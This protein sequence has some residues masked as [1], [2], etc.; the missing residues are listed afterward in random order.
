MTIQVS[1]SDLDS[2]DLVGTLTR[3]TTQVIP[4][5]SWKNPGNHLQTILNDSWYSLLLEFFDEFCYATSHFYRGKGIRSI[6]TPVTT[7]SISS[8]MGLG[9]DSLPV[10]AT[11]NGEPVYLADSMQFILEVGARINRKGVYY[12]ACSFRGEEVDARH[13]A[14]FAHSEVEIPGSLDDLL[15]LAGEYVH[16]LVNHFYQYSAEGVLASAGTLAHLERALAYQGQFPRVRFEEVFNSYGTET[17]CFK[18]LAPGIWTITGAGERRLMDEVGEAVWLTHLPQ[19]TAPFYQ[20]P[21]EGT[22]YCLSA[23]LLMGEGETLGAGERCRD[24]E[25]LLR[26]L[27]YH[28]VDPQDYAWYVEMKETMPLQTAG[29]GMGVERFLLWLMQTKDIR[30]M[31]LCL[32]DNGFQHQP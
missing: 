21:E 1:E 19:L 22:S 3:P 10:A 9:S 5:E 30:N 24:K 6:F 12:I 11:I 17:G 15:T 16:H 32:R 23:D 27:E 2:V 28:Q 26:S 8:P 7:N 29:F 4:P 25:T 14:Q 31:M 13:L 18:E 20:Q